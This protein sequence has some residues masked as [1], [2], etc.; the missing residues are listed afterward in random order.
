ML[1][2]GQMVQDRDVFLQYMAKQDLAKGSA[3]GSVGNF[4]KFSLIFLEIC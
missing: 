1:N 3:I 2:I 4:R